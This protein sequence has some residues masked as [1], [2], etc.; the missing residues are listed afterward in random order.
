MAT[1]SLPAVFLEDSTVIGLVTFAKNGTFT[2]ICSPA[3]ADA[4][5][6]V[7]TKRDRGVKI[8]SSVRPHC[9]ATKAAVPKEASMAFP[10]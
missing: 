2:T 4:A 8:E 7:H 1:L 3:P 9:G 10:F 5:G 6:H